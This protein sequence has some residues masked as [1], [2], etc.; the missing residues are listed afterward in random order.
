MVA[1]DIGSGKQ[2]RFTAEMRSRLVRCA[3]GS[4]GHEAY[5]KALDRLLRGLQIEAAGSP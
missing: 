1:S 4:K 5:Q 3:D 2:H